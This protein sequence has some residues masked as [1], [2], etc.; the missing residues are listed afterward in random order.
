MT[1][2]VKTQVSPLQL[3]LR[4]NVLKN[5]VPRTLL[6]WRFLD[7]LH[8]FSS[9]EALLR[10]VSYI[11]KLLK[12]YC[13]WIMSP[14]Q[15]Y[16]RY[17]QAI[18]NLMTREFEVNK[19]WGKRARWKKKTENV[20]YYLSTTSDINILCYKIYKKKFQLMRLTWHILNSLLGE[21]FHKYFS[22]LRSINAKP[23]NCF[24]ENFL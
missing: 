21:L 17:T 23:C 7:L 3:L 1:S 5:N 6:L 12:K 22:C 24:L 19:K 18:D 20:T 14:E 4:K 9:A 16:Y 13:Q 10:Q 2:F 8:R 11:K 15:I